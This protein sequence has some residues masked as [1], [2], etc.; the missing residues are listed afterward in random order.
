MNSIF[1]V[2]NYEEYLL[3]PFNPTTIKQAPLYPDCPLK[4]LIH[5]FT[6]N[7]SYTPNMEIRPGMKIVPVQ[8]IS[9]VALKFRMHNLMFF[10]CQC[11]SIHAVSTSG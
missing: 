11:F 3:D 8:K 9:F 10:V 7:R 2:N 5:G 1:R 6:G 4:V